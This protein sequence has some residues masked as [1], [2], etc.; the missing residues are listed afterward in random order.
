MGL[1]HGLAH[2]IQNIL[3]LK[4]PQLLGQMLRIDRLGE[5]AVAAGGLQGRHAHAIR[6]IGV[7]A[8]V[9]QG[10]HHFAIPAV[11]GMVQWG[12]VGEIARVGIGALF[13]QHA[14]EARLAQTDRFVQRREL[15]IGHIGLCAPVE[16]GAQAFRVPCLQC[17][18]QAAIARAWRFARQPR[19]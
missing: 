2:N 17:I 18:E 5:I 14:H 8:E 3:A 4:H 1:S 11:Q 9:Q 10:A 7:G 12:F 6:E 13:Q 19:G 15:T 16:Q